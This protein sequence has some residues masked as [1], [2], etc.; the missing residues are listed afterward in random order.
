MPLSANSLG[1][2]LQCFFGWRLGFGWFTLGKKL[3]CESEVLGVDGVCVVCGKSCE[4]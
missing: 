3:V 1:S 2:G 4:V